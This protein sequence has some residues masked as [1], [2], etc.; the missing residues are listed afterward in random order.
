MCDWDPCLLDVMLTAL[1]RVWE[2]VS[3]LAADPTYTP[4]SECV[5]VTEHCTQAVWVDR[6]LYVTRR[7][8]GSLHHAEIRC[9]VLERW[10][11]SRCFNL[12]PRVF[13]A[14][15]VCDRDFSLN[16]N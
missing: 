12:F 13:V 10:R 11:T 7:M 15:H 2:R 3:V 5:G 1:I 6:R 9:E 8:Q 14:R 4:H 16:S